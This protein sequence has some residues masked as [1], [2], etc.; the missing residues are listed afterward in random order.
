MLEVIVGFFHQW[1]SSFIWYFQTLHDVVSMIV[2]K[3]G[4]VSPSL[5]LGCLKRLL[6]NPLFERLGLS[7]SPSFVNEEGEF[8]FSDAHY[9][10]MI[11]KG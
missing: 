1:I 7:S 10:A 5:L 9:V 6:C 4:V 8:H 11:R 3:K 2:V